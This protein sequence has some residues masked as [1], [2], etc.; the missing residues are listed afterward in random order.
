[1]MD[2]TNKVVTM[3]IDQIPQW[4]SDAENQI[5]LCL[6]SSILE[7]KEIQY[8]YNGKDYK[9]KMFHNPQH[10]EMQFNTHVKMYS[11]LKGSRSG[12]VIKEAPQPLQDRLKH[13]VRDKQ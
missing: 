2:L 3:Q 8:N 5:G 9:I 11:Y 12:I 13:F 1:M 6:L 7:F 4:D 10:K